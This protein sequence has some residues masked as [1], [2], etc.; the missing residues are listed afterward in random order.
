MEHPLVSIGLP[1]YNGELYLRQA[2]DS[3]LGQDYTNFE[4]IVSDNASQD[5]TEVICR[6]FLAREGRIRYFRQ[7]INLGAPANFEF[8]ARQ[9]KG[10]YFMWA[11][12]DDFWAPEY[13]RR[14]VE[15]LESH[16]DAVLCCT[17]INFL[18]G[19]GSLYT[20]YA[21]YSNIETLSMPPV[22]RFH[23]LIRRMGWFAIYGLMRRDAV[24]R[25]P[26]GQGRF[27]YDV[28]LL[29]HLLL[30]GNFVKRPERLFNYRVLKAKT[31]ED[32]SLIFQSPSPLSNTPYTL[33]AADVWRVVCESSLTLPE[34]VQ[35]FSDF[36]VTLSSENRVWRQQIVTEMGCTEEIDDSRAAAQLALILSRQIPL[37]EM[38]HYPVIAALYDKSDS[39]L[40][41]ARNTLAKSEPQSGPE[42]LDQIRRE[43]TERFNQGKFEEASVLYM[44][45]LRIQPNS[46]LWMD[47]ATAR[48]ASQDFQQAEMGLSRA[49]LMEPGNAQAA[50]KM[51]LL[52][53]NLG[54]YTEA[55]P[56]LE[57]S[58][59][60]VPPS[61]SEALSGL[62]DQCRAW[63]ASQP[64]VNR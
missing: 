26:L 61:Q 10:I 9:A 62:L 15:E 34:K 25:L 13:V 42:A 53:T 24:L 7:N 40:G 12:H 16:P 44:K 4:L 3:L 36:I 64:C 58:M 50:L 51:G 32:Y 55:I 27:G 6:E 11:A 19:Q 22:R 59:C 20:E 18:D 35:S 54:R 57:Q 33:L 37:D 29:A 60:Q 14:C 45:A 1:V 48:L 43:A 5:G 47:W 63:A 39:V 49:L 52:L 21:N 31:S 56:C 41:I 38:R 30:M 8:V 2:L 28:T 23:E 17:E 46:D